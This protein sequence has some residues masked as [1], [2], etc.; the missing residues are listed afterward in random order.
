MHRDLTSR[1]VLLHKGPNTLIAKLCDFNL[2]RVVPVV[3]GGGYRSELRG[4][5]AGCL[6]S[7]PNGVPMPAV[8]FVLIRILSARMLTS[9][10]RE[11][12]LWAFPVVLLRN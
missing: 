12:P 2:S 7:H 1:N 5:E 11:A 10:G 3:D 8:V 6:A 9:V 4:L